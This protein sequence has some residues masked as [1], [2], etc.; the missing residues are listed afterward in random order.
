MASAS[1][2]AAIHFTLPL[3]IGLHLAPCF[4]ATGSAGIAGGVATWRE[5]SVQSPDPNDMDDLAEDSEDVA[6]FMFAGS[7]LHR[8]KSSGI[9]AEAQAVAGSSAGAVPGTAKVADDAPLVPPATEGASAWEAA[10]AT[11]VFESKQIVETEDSDV[12]SWVFDESNGAAVPAR[13]LQAE[14]MLQ[15]AEDAPAQFF[16]EKTAERALRIY[17]HAKWLAE[18]NYARAAEHRYR[19]AAQLAKR[20]RRSVLA[21]HSL[22][23][24]GYF[25]IHWRRTSEAADA[26]QESMKLNTKSNPLAPYLHG[27]LE[28]KAAAGD[29]DRLRAAEELILQSGEQPSE[30]LEV[31]RSRLIGEIS[32]WREAEG[33][34]KQCFSNSDVAY[35]LICLCGHAVTFLRSM[36]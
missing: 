36:F 7:E 12:G 3:L 26:L 10:F 27:I 29:S 33:S 28:R 30:E 11:G 31:E 13:M 23:R 16:K 21:S 4:E 15:V 18:R 35:V 20:S 2:T 1:T 22:A 5:T 24:L 17:Y 8:P 14:V 32:Y 25:L 6:S 34:A 19:M 9:P